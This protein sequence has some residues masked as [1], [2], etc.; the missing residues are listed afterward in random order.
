MKEGWNNVIKYMNR[1]CLTFEFGQDILESFYQL[2]T[3]K[4]REAS[5]SQASTN[6]F[7]TLVLYTGFMQD[8]SHAAKSG[9]QTNGN[10][11]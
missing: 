11:L 8:F 2:F 5:G 6:W 7:E 4:Q 1:F 9:K 10:T 3:K